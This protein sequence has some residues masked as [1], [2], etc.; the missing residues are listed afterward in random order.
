MVITILE[1]KVSEEKW[2]EFKASYRKLDKNAP[3]SPTQSFLVQSR[4]KPGVWK[5]ITLWNNKEVLQNVRSSGKTPK[6]VELF[7]NVGAE[8][9][10]SIL[11]VREVFE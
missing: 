1:G 8:P 4:D 10:L 5:I 6:G 9:T 11:D 7:Q 2:E 3:N